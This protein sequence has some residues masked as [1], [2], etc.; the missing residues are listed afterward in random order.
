MV[1]IQTIYAIGY[2]IFYEKKTDLVLPCKRYY[3]TKGNRKSFKMQT[4][5]LLHKRQIEFRHSIALYCRLKI[6]ISKARY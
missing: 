2:E 5:N 6:G 3:K 1:Y 4:E